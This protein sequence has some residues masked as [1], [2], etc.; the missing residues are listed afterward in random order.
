MLLEKALFSE[1][2]SRRSNMLAEL[3]FKGKVLSN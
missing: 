2:V 3:L 1:C